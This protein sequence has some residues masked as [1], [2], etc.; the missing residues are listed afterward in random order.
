MAGSATLVLT[1]SNTYTGATYLNAGELSVSGTANLG[2]AAPTSNVVFNGGTLQITGTNLTN[3]STI[4]HTV[5]F[6]P[7]ATVGLDIN[8]AANTFTVDQPL[9]QGSGGLTKLGAGILILSQPDAYTGPTYI[10]AGTLQ[11]GTGGAAGTISRSALLDNGALV[12]DLTGTFTQGTNF[13][14]I[15]F[16]TG[17]V[18]NSGAGTL[19][20]NAANYYTGATTA[21]AGTIA[22]NNNLAIQDSPLVTAGTRRR[23]SRQRRDHPDDRRPE[24]R[25]GQS[26]RP[27]TCSAPAKQCHRADA[28]PE[29]LGDLRRR[30]FRRR[31]PHDPHHDRDRRPGPH[32]QQHLHGATHLNAGAL[33]LA[34]NGSILSTSG[35]T[36]SGGG[37]T[38][39]NTNAT[40]AAVTPGSRNEHHLQR[41]QHHLRQHLRRSRLL[42]NDRFG[43]ARQR[44]VECRGKHQSGQH[45]QP[46][47]DTQRP[48]GRGRRNTSTVTFS[49]ASTTPNATTNI[50]A[51]AG[52]S[53]PARPDPRNLGHHRH[54]CREP[55]GLR[56]L[57]R[58]VAS[59]PRR[60]RRYHQ[61]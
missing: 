28:Q 41:R 23:D 31:R 45:G 36:L 3:F 46:D 49:A 27:A 13:P 47:A 5:V 53:Y 44:A 9:N 22:L 12:A 11:A 19:V 37:I 39:T 59:R 30:H 40:D 17:P 42:P 55:D 4:G 35:I 33:N 58:L 34:G 32:R 8:N 21:S 52:A 60:D 54:R 56:R 18:T 51:V 10:S 29:L 26:R 50:I 7:G 48:D 61:R 14:S 1:G 20:L 15:I 2:A 6:N 24:R 43:R 57:Q 25:N 16:G 38:L